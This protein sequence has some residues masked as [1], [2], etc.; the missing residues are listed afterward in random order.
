[1]TEAKASFFKTGGTLDPHAPSYVERP[2]DTLLYNTIV[3]GEYC[4]VLTARQMG[5]SSLMA[6]TAARLRS[7]GVSVAMI[8]ISKFGITNL[9]ADQWYYTLVNSLVNQFR[10]HLDLP[11]W[12]N[13]RAALSTVQR[14]NDF[15]EYVLLPGTPGRLVVCVDE[16][17]TTLSL[18]F[19]DD[20]FATVR[21]FYNMRATDADFKRLTF[22]LLGVAAPADLI[23]DRTRTPFNIGRAVPLGELSR[24]DAGPL[25]QGL[26]QAFPG[27]GEQLLSRIFHWTAGHPYLT[28]KLCVEI[29]QQPQINWSDQAIDRLV[30]Q[31]FFDP[32]GSKD[33]NL[34]S[35][36]RYLAAYPELRQ[37]L[38]LY[39]QVYSGERIADD[40]RSPQ[41]NALKLAGLVRAEGGALQVRNPIYRQVFGKEW[42][43]EK[44]PKQAS[45]RSRLLIAIAATLLLLAFAGGGVFIFLDRQA[46]DRRVAAVQNVAGNCQVA[47]AEGRRLF[48]ERRTPTQQLDMFALRAGSTADAELSAAA[49]CVAPAIEASSLTSEQRTALKS[50]ICAALARRELSDAAAAEIGCGA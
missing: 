12:W 45:G 4:Y 32:G 10:Q 11:N 5:K 13:E 1:M 49:R 30:G 40:E 44:L 31:L 33:D 24:A 37:L 21:A 36:W 7:K 47:P 2:A 46:E 15:I 23:K 26:N 27:H 19:S 17:D 35:V 43:A 16:I 34:H 20:F 39:K 28:Q 6:R 42:I 18:A 41:Q 29:T 3:A 9:T 48:F 38:T 14:F 25:A 50:A 8:D 22:V